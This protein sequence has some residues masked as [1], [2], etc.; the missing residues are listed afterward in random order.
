MPAGPSG[1]VRHRTLAK[2]ADDVNL[3]GIALML[4]IKITVLSSVQTCDLAF[5]TASQHELVITHLNLPYKQH[6]I[7]TVLTKATDA[8]PNDVPDG[9]E[10]RGGRSGTPSAPRKNKDEE[11]A[12]TGA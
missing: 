11:E 8:N 5:N 12:H 2:Q 4:G 7:D 9:D 3:H 1:L 10:R 6:W